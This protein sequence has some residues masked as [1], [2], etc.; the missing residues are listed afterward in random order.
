MILGSL[1]FS[2]DGGSEGMKIRRQISAG[3]AGSPAYGI[4]STSVGNGSTTV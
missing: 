4:K 1:I 3:G 2:Q